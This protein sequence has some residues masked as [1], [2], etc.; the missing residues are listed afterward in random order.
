MKLFIAWTTVVALR[1]WAVV[2]AQHTI[3]VGQS[4]LSFSPSTVNAAAG[5]TVQFVFYPSNHSVI[6]GDFDNPCHPS[7]GGFFSGFL[8]ATTSGPSVCLSSNKL[9]GITDAFKATM[10]V[11]TVTS[12]DPVYFYC[13]QARH[14]QSG[15]VGIINPGYTAEFMLRC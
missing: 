1:V 5:D 9:H 15:M 10:F 11:Y 8:Y 14:C 7:N 4:G 2:A 6:Q 3:D 12:T 13:G